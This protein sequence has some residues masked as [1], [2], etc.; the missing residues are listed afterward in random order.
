MTKPP[1]KS[2][3]I[4][5]NTEAPEAKSS[6][7]QKTNRLLPILVG[8]AAILG[9]AAFF[10]VNHTGKSAM[11]TETNPHQI[12]TDAPPSKPIQ[13]PTNETAPTETQAKAPPTAIN[14]TTPPIKTQVEAPPTA[15][16]AAPLKQPAERAIIETAA[17]KEQVPQSDKEA[18]QRVANNLDAIYDIARPLMKGSAQRTQINMIEALE[19]QRHQA[20]ANANST[21]DIE[22]LED[23]LA[24]LLGHFAYDEISNQIQSTTTAIT[25]NGLDGFA[26]LQWDDHL[27][28]KTRAQKLFKS[29]NTLRALQEIQKAQ[30]SLQTFVTSACETLS[31]LAKNDADQA[32]TDS[33][34]TTYK[35]LLKLQPNHQAALEFLHRHAYPAGSKIDAPAGIRLAFIP[36][37]TFQMGTQTTEFERDP[38]EILHT[39]TL[40]HAVY[41]SDTEITQAQWTAV[42]HA[43]PQEFPSEG[44]S[45][46]PQM[47][48]HSVSWYEAQAFCEKL[49]ALDPRHHYR[50]PTEAE[51]EYACRAATNTPYNNGRDQLQLSEANI[52]AT[53]G[54]L[55]HEH[56]IAVA[57]YAPNN[58][59]LYDMHGNV[60]EWTNDWLGNYATS[61]ISDPLGATAS[62]TDKNLRTK[63]LRGGSYYDEAGMARSGNRWESPP[64]IATD[65]IGF[66]V[67]CTAQF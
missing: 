33:A 41:I 47:P 44:T 37:G 67:L 46:G 4:D 38:D 66:R 48:I 31:T 20:Q 60:W 6:T 21:A 14:T 2:V 3:L 11:P 5:L 56:A 7:A 28:S 58:W 51:W 16:E 9:I 25:N 40:T 62:G 35:A 52:F 36:A 26:A 57:S 54:E 1:K 30:A 61:A 59:G 24:T 64:S 13:A 23:K 42:M 45:V 39:V 19:L 34:I 63:I 43:M 27:R 50:L 8:S 10:I 18:R 22:L 65:Y 17:P 55:P 12:Q 32:N 53:T 15:I 29:G 49:S